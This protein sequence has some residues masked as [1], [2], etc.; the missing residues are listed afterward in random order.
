MR[1]TI[2]ILAFASLVSLVV[3]A[4]RTTVE[5]RTL[6][7]I[8]QAAQKETGTLRVAWG[9]DLASSSD[10][11][12]AAFRARFPG[13][14]V[15]ITTDLSKY[16]DSR[17]DRAYQVSNRRDD[18]YD[19]AVLQALH[20]FPRW[21]AEGRLLNYK[22]APWNDIYPQ[23]VDRDGAYTGLFV[24]GFG[25]NIVYNP[26]HF[27]TPFA[28]NY[29]DYLKPEWKDKLILTYPNDDDAV[30]YLFK[31]IVQKYGWGYIDRLVAQGVQWVR[32][33]ATPSLVLSR[34]NTAGLSFT[35]Y[36]SSADIVAREGTDVYMVWPQTGTIF[37]STPVPETAK[38]FISF[39]LD[40]EWQNTAAGGGFATR[41]SIDKKGVFKQPGL[42]P[43]SYAAFMANR[44]QVEAWRFQFETTLGTP[45]GGN[46]TYY[47]V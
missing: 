18:G 17:I 4:P 41:K 38:L 27:N 11:V 42:D 9:G 39:L 46:P 28:Q 13:I 20:D 15:N 25:Q 5:T 30:L 6:D 37:K 26:N 7:Q 40:N 32:G 24:F 29:L 34:N 2:N 19:V 12:T 36:P 21:K 45:Q 43:T 47:T 14:N 35:S 3:A 1:T 16:W 10:G 22:A 44:Q 23:F 8:Y 31:L 33:T